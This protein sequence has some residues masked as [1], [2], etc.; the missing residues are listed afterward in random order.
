MGCE[1]MSSPQGSGAAASDLSLKRLHKACEITLER[2]NTIANQT[3]SLMGR[4]RSLPVSK[5]KRLDVYIQKRK[6]DEAHDAY[7][8][9]RNALLEAIQN[10]PYLVTHKHEPESD[11][12]GKRAPR[13]GAYRRRTG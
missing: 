3:C 6:E 13:I 4:L 10:D 1:H 9:A 11:L 5:D 12:T 8:K 2:Y 7:Q